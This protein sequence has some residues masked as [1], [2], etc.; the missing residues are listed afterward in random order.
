MTEPILQKAKLNTTFEEVP[1]VNRTTSDPRIARGDV[2]GDFVSNSTI[3]TGWDRR[4]FIL[5]LHGVVSL[6]WGI[7]LAIFSARVVPV[8]WYLSERGRK[9][10]EVTNVLVALAS[11][12]TTMHITYIL[13]GVCDQYTSYL[14]VE[15]FTVGQL[16]WMQGVKELSVFAKFPDK[17]NFWSKKRI[18][19]ILQPE[20][21]FKNF[22]FG[23][24]GPCGSDPSDLTLERNPYLDEGLQAAVDKLSFVVG[25][26]LGNYNEQVA[27]NTTSRL[28]GRT[29]RKDSY[30]YGVL[31]GLENGLLEVPGAQFVAQCSSNSTEAEAIWRSV[32][33]ERS[34]PEPLMNGTQ[35]AGFRDAPVPAQMRSIDSEAGSPEDE[36]LGIFHNGM[37]ALV[38]PTADGALITVE[39]DGPR[40][41]V[42]V[43]SWKTLPKLVYAQTIDFTGRA[44]RVEDAKTYP[45][46]IG[47]ATWS[48]LEGMA[49][50]A[51]SG[52]SLQ[53]VLKK[54]TPPP[55]QVLETILADGGKAAITFINAHFWGQYNPRKANRNQ[56]SSAPPRCDSNNRTVAEHWR[57][58]NSHNLGYI[59]IVL[60]TGIGIFAIWMVLRLKTRRRMRGDWT[61][62][63][64]EAFELGKDE[65]VGQEQW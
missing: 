39:P 21:F 15:G 12:L 48:T 32:F 23:D 55:S 63:V 25:M 6:C 51:R 18:V 26:Q 50:A 7:A 54:A 11:T 24:W 59:A 49:R 8:A 38:Q 36:N 28:A 41:K 53:A 27:G 35:L 4:L 5:L 20:S 64:A 14:V 62:G 43:C 29:Y 16:R 30:A 58:G 17:E 31:G 40:S 60:T 10:P 33:P 1:L 47:R 9:S 57:F 65:K 56:P 22:W 34:P 45:I 2:G 37:Y 61:L 13:Q 42:T 19:A 3:T 44:L 52:A 46:V